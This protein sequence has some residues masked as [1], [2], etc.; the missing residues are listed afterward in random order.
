MMRKLVLGGAALAGAAVWQATRGGAPE[1]LPPIGGADSSEYRWRGWRIALSTLGEGPPLLLI[2]AV[3]AAATSRE[4]QQAAPLLARTHRV[5]APDLLGFGRSERPD[6]RY[7]A[8]LYADLIA[9]LAREVVGEPCV[10]VANSLS[11]AHAIVAADREPGLFSALVLVQPTGITRLQ[12]SNPVM[13]A[14]GGL[15]RTPAAGTTMFQALTSRAGV[16]YFLGKSYHDKA[17]VTPEM[18]EY[19]HNLTRQ[20]GARFAPAAFVGFAL[21]ADV[22]ERVKRIR[23]PVLLTWGSH[24]GTNPHSERLAF[25]EARPDWETE[26]VEGTGDLPHDERPGPWVERVS[27][28]LAVHSP[29]RPAPAAG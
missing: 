18:V 2:H 24:P 29:A 12:E 20:P 3:H 15:I 22:R 8:D 14:V 26:V 5:V 1:P 13:G 7:S 28:F 27:R 23:Q 21:N 10:L 19:H 25:Q 11:G 6:T 4:W 17:C 16:R 9:D